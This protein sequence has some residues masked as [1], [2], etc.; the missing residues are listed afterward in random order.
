MTAAKIVPTTTG[1]IVKM[2]EGKIVTKIVKKLKNFGEIET[3]A[4][5]GEMANYIRVKSF[6]TFS[7]LEIDSD[8][9][10]ISLLN[11]N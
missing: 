9:I 8:K 5:T 3:K 6:R 1:T 4:R 10:L 11:F 2:V 7:W